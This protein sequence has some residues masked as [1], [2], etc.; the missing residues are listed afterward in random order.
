MT[1]AADKRS[2]GRRPSVIKYRGGAMPADRDVRLPVVGHMLPT[3]GDRDDTCALYETCLQAH[4]D[5]HRG[6]Q[7][8][9]VPASCPA[10][11]RWRAAR[12]ERATDFAAAPSG[13]H[14]AQA[15]TWRA[16]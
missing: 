4:T 14:L 13:G 3:R 10:P 8:A 5:A 15:G 7:C 12:R 1:R 2:L 16:W 9:E 11:C 6:R